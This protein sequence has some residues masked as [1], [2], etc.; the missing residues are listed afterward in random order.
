MDEK[1]VS[2]GYK[3]GKGY[4]LPYKGIEKRTQTSDYRL[5]T[6]NKNYCPSSAAFFKIFFSSSV[7][8]W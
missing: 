2:T 6:T 4:R 5:Q 3:G 8:K 1:E 7:K